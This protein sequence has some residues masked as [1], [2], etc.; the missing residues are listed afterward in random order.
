MAPRDQGKVL[1]VTLEEE[2]ARMQWPW[3]QPNATCPHF[4]QIR[5]NS[6]KICRN[7]TKNSEFGHLPDTS[8]GTNFVPNSYE[9]VVNVS[10]HATLHKGHTSQSHGQRM[11]QAPAHVH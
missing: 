9:F 8:V 11:Y 2:R 10:K 1:G 3:V 7:P 5:K 6:Y 4:R